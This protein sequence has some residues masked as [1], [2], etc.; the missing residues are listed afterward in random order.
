MFPPENLAPYIG[1]FRDLLDAHDLDYGMFGHVDA[2]VLHV[3]PLLDLKSPEVMD[4]VRIITDQVVDLTKKY[5]GLLW[6]EHGK[7][8]R[9][10]YAP[11][12]FGSLYPAICQIKALFDPLN[13]LNPGKIAGPSPE[14]PLLKIDEVPTRGSGDRRI[15]ASL[16][17]TASTALLCNGNG[18]CHNYDLD[19]RM[20]P[21]WKATR[22]RRY[23]P[24]GRAGLMREWVTRMS[25]KGLHAIPSLHG[26]NKL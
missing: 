23:T 14:S 4:T 12:F 19:D 24:K 17:A 8:V 20:C 3:R 1:E 26:S 18:A 15:T 16:Q 7:G 10:E 5:N 25:D 21:S 22:D 13:R 2:G 9:S 11:I 6:G